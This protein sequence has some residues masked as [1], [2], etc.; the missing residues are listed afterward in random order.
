[1]EVAKLAEQAGDSFK[2]LSGQVKGT[3]RYMAPEQAEGRVEDIDERTD[4]Y[5][6]GAILYAI[7]TLHPP[8]TGDTVNEVLT[9]VAAGTI[10]PPTS[11]NPRNSHISRITGPPTP[12]AEVTPPE[13]LHCPD[14]RI[15]SALSAVAMKALTRDKNRRYQTVASLQ[16][17]IAAYQGGFATSAEGPAPCGCCCC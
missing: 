14:R 16:Q 17:D 7:L 2:T 10:S 8:V 3:P 13:L 6:L 9:K 1:M 11:Y 5:A 15:P 4:I 12:A